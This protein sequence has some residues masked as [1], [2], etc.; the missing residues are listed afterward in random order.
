MKKTLLLILFVL[1]NTAIF[2]QN[3]ADRD[4]SLNINSGFSFSGNPA[5]IYTNAIQPDGKILSGGYFNTYWVTTTKYFNR[6]SNSGTRDTAIPLQIFDARVRCIAIQPDGKILI[7]GDFTHYN[8]G[9]TNILWNRL[10]RLNADGSRDTSFTCS[11]NSLIK[12][13]IVRS[14]GKIIIAG[15]FST[16]NGSNKKF[17]SLLNSD[18]SLASS[19]GFT[20]TYG[21]SNV[22]V[23]AVAIQTDG[24]ILLGGDIDSGSYRIK[25]YRLN[26]TA[27][28]LDLTFVPLGFNDNVKTLAIQS[29]GKILVGGSFT[30]TIFGS[31]SVNRIARLNIDGSLDTSFNIGTGFDNDVNTIKLQS[32]GKILVGGSFTTFNGVVSNR[33]ARLNSDGTLDTSF[34]TGTGFND[35][36][37]AITFQTDGKIVVGGR[38]TSYKGISVNGLVRLNGSSIL[39]TNDF[40]KTKITL[41]PNPTKDI[42]NFTLS[43][44]NTAYEYEISNMLG[45][46]VSYGDLNSNSISIINLANGVYIVKIR[47]NEGVLTEKFIKE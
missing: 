22:S 14:D 37:N 20:Y 21:S 2:A 47:T 25:I 28:A 30:S 29:D 23:D 6:I 39:S 5:E 43:E 46:K 45:E 27:T 32:N 3:E 36:V 16:V 26:A 17:L 9:T 10:I 42:L 13:I 18:G 40:S 7:G 24:K 19:S 33:L 31:H 41:Y 15:S 35:N 38:F 12:Q 44:T 8:D 4:I 34:D 1:T 11:V